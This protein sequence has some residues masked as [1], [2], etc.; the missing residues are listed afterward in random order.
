MDVSCFFF[1]SWLK[2]SDLIYRFIK[3]TIL[4]FKI[5]YVALRVQVNNFFLKRLISFSS[6]F[7][8]ETVAQFHQSKS[9]K[10]MIHRKAN[11]RIKNMLYFV[12]LF[13]SSRGYLAVGVQTSRPNRCSK[14][15]NQRFKHTSSVSR[16][17]GCRSSPYFLE[18][19]F[20]LPAN[21]SYVSLP[22]HCSFQTL[23]Q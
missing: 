8:F 16:R 23:Q 5:T 4:H 22:L 11:T 10:F 3:R 18:W 21:A 6:L 14:I 7:I 12:K 17:F 20:P 1:T 19:S 13:N 9:R 15:S 2:L